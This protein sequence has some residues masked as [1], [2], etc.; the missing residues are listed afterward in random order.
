M[1]QAVKL[2]VAQIQINFL[3]GAMQKL[4]G[5]DKMFDLVRYARFVHSP[6]E[7]KQT[8]SRYPKETNELKGKDSD[9]HHGWNSANLAMYRFIMEI[10]DCENSLLEV[11]NN[12]DFQHSSVE[13]QLED[14]LNE[15]P[16]LDT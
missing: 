14:M 7:T 9:W 8:E 16:F 10:V 2:S 3:R 12:Q 15:Y 4:F 13:K 5:N 1:T 6:T 11:N